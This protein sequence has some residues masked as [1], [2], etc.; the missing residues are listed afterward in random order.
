MYVDDFLDLQIPTAGMYPL[1]MSRR[2]DSSGPSD[3]PMGAGWSSSLTAHLYYAT[4]L[5]A[6]PS[7]YSYEA[8]VVM[9]DGVLY[10]FTISG[11][12]FTPPSGR[13]DTL[14]KNADGTYLLTPQFT[15]SV[16]KFN[17][18]GSLASLTDDYGNVITYTNDASGRLQRMADASGSGRYLDVT[19][20]T[21]GRLA[22]VT[23]NAGRVLK[24]FYEGGNGTLTSFSDPSVSSDSG[25]RSRYYGYV[26]GRFGPVLSRIEDRWH[27]VITDVEWY[28]SGQVKSYTEGRYDGTST[29]EGEKYTYQYFAGSVAKTDSFGSRN[30]P[31]NAAGLVSNYTTYDGLGQLTGETT[32]FGTRSYSYN[33]RGN[34]SSTTDALA[35]WTYAY[36][37]NF[38]DKVTSI[39]S[40][41]P[42]IWAG[43]TYEYNAPGTTAAGALAKVFRSGTTVPRRISLQRMPMTATVM[44]RTSPTRMVCRRRTYTAPPGI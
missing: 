39:T 28:P 13:H 38:P 19:W 29:S 33:A 18:D 16:Y 27:R 20:G 32:P 43:W 21:D 5:L 36:D 31:Y 11:S 41:L 6:A 34:V 1:T 15:R 8:D 7:T 44:S 22:S 26:P 30:F 42:G 2:Y 14:V 25:Q 17:A 4:Y 37:A 40:N 35:T 9:P 23:D 12:T 24:Y 10:Q 3:G